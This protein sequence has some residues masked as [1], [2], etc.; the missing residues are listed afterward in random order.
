MSCL[1]LRNKQAGLLSL[2]FLGVVLRLAAKDFWEEKPFTAWNEQEAMKMLSESPW[3]R[4]LLVL[5]G[6]LAPANAANRL[7][8]LPSLSSA[9]GNRGSGVGQTGS[10]N[11]SGSDSVSLYISWFSSG[12]VRQALGRLAQIR[13]HAP[14]SEVK[15][16]VD[17]PSEDYQIAVAGPLMEAF[18]SLSLADFK[19][20]TFL[21]SKKDKSKT[22]PLKSY[23]APKERKDGMAIFSFE[24]QF[25]GQPAFDLEDQEVVFVASGKKVVLK[26]SFKLAKM[27]NS[28]SLDI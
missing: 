6:T 17:E 3:S 25:N 9:G 4:T 2:L 28:G 7:T 16:F 10:G 5:G 23:V 8:D 20:K 14:E 18:N 1:I 22:L 12:R 19:P 15:K 11:G 26:A 24:R 13:N 21:S 27:M